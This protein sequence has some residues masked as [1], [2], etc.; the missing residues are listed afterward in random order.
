MT[1]H[2]VNSTSGRIESDE[3]QRKPR[4][5]SP[6][7]QL[8]LNE[9]LQLLSIGQAHQPIRYWI[10]SSSDGMPDDVGYLPRY[11]F[12]DTAVILVERILLGRVKSQYTD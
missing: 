6:L 8:G 4:F 9:A 10:I 7:R 1:L 11:C 2:I 12:Y 3:Y 5:P